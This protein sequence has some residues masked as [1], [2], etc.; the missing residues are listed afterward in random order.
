MS[1][2]LGDTINSESVEET[3]LNTIGAVSQT[4][5]LY[6]IFHA[7]YERIIQDLYDEAPKE[8]DDD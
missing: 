1:I 5:V 4:K 7:D 3:A 2:S 6:E 8:V